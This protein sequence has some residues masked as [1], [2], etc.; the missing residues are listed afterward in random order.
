MGGDCFCVVEEMC[1]NCD[2]ILLVHDRYEH[3][4]NTLGFVK[5][6]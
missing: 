4:N 5:R 3:A 6:G 2:W 1:E